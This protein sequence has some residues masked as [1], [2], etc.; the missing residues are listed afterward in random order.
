MK[1]SLFVIL[2]QTSTPQI[3]HNKNMRLPTLSKMT[4]VKV[5]FLSILLLSGGDAICNPL[6]TVSTCEYN[7]NGE[8]EITICG[9]REM[10][11]PAS[12]LGQAGNP[13]SIDG[14]YYEIVWLFDGGQFIVGQYLDDGNDPI[15][16]TETFCL[17]YHP[18][19][20]RAE[21]S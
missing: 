3:N 19:N 20:F 18:Q 5:F 12:S 10:L 9:L 21:I 14:D 4:T 7:G 6:Y 11:N 2:G 13:G 8:L 15:C 16:I 17:G 1:I